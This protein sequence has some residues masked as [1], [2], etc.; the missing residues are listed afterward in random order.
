M[1]ADRIPE[2]QQALVEADLDG[3]LFAVFQRNDPVSLELL[4]FPE[5]AL[6]TR[7]C[8]YLIPASGEPRKLTH[9]L[10]PAMLDHLPGGNSHYLTWKQHRESLAGLVDGHV[11]LAA[12]Y[13]PENGLPSVSRLDA[14]TAELL[15]ATGVEPISSADLVQSFAAV[16]SPAQLETHRRACAHLH[17]IVR[18]AF[19]LVAGKLLSGEEIVEHA[20]QRFILGR[21]D[22]EGLWTE[23]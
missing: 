17:A 23:S 10:E 7:R 16:W 1:L 20:V 4:G 12:Q 19:D 18:Q 14:G 22:E 5:D 2:I 8:Y 13:S 15:R 21:F 3:W 6:V 11:R 9:R